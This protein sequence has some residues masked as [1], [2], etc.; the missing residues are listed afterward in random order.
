MHPSENIIPFSTF[1][2]HGS[3]GGGDCGISSIGE[4]GSALGKFAGSEAAAFGM[5]LTEKLL[6]LP[7]F[8]LGVLM[9]YWSVPLSILLGEIQFWKLYGK[10]DDAYGW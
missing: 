7:A 10:R 2:I 5:G 8:L 1:F 3:L 9:L 6:N 4:V